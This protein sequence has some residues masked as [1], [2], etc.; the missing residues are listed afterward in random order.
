MSLLFCVSHDNFNYVPSADSRPAALSKSSTPCML[1]ACKADVPEERRE[2]HSR[3]HDQV[4]R[5]FSNVVV[6]ETNKDEAET[7][8]RC[9][10][11]MLHRVFAT[12]RGPGMCRIQDVGCFGFGSAR[13]MSSSVFQT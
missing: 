13:L 12:P 8:K 10:S 11:N 7:Q 5:S 2:V 1:V 9:L 3:F 4:K 6:S